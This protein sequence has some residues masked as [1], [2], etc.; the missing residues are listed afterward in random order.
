M[1]RIMLTRMLVPNGNLNENPGRLTEISPGRLPKGIPIF[2]AIQTIP[3]TAAR[4]SPSTINHLPI[5][6]GSIS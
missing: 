5:V 1:V 4:T 2:P 3:P 6:P